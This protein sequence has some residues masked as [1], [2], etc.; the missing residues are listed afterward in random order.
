MRPFIVRT[1]PIHSMDPGVFLI[2]RLFSDR[3]YFME[4]IKNEY[5]FD[6]RSGFSQ[7]SFMY[8]TQEK[9]FFGYTVYNGDFSTQE[10]I[11]MSAGRPVNHEIE[12]WYPLEAFELVE[13]YKKGEL[14]GKL[15]EVAST[16]DEES[17]RVIM[18]VKHK[19]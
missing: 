3:Y 1:P 17:N 11:Y 9:A 19:E 4:T 8:D 5:N 13:S 14:K 7:T 6:T 10:E 12:L 15:K 16:L 2:L 18:L